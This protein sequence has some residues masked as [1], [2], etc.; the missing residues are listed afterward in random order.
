MPRRLRTPEPRLEEGFWHRR[1][2]AVWRSTSHQA[3]LADLQNPH[4]HRLWIVAATDTRHDTGRGGHKHAESA[5]VDGWRDWR[6]LAIGDTLDKRTSREVP[7]TPPHS[8]WIQMPQSI[9]IAG[10]LRRFGDAPKG[11]GK[12]GRTA[13]AGWRARCRL[14][15]ACMRNSLNG[16]VALAL[17]WVPTGDLPRTAQLGG[18]DYSR[19]VYW[20]E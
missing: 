9:H 18:K 13:V 7:L 8:H 10:V 16:K 1:V 11:R 14:P 5:D 19:L 3:A 12:L 15:S 17:S 4:V 20:N 2:A 6:N